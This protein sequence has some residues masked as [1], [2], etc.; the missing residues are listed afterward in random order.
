M[1]SNN[2]IHAT[3]IVLAL[4]AITAKAQVVVPSS[5][6]VPVMSTAMSQVPTVLAASKGVQNASEQASPGG[7][8]KQLEALQREKAVAELRKQV[9]EIN[10]TREASSEATKALPA[11]AVPSAKVRPIGVI[12]MPPTTA[13]PIMEAVKPDYS[14]LSIISFRGDTRADVVL[15]NIVS[16]IHVGDKLSDAKVVAI[17][18][19][20]G[21]VIERSLTK[22]GTVTN[23]PHEDALHGSVRTT[24]R[25]TL[26]RALSSPAFTSSGTTAQAH[27]RPFANSAQ[28]SLPPV[29]PTFLDVANVLVKR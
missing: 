19:N 1:P 10:G 17:S 22:A 9:R 6:A 4:C 25:I 5:L 27:D 12:G 16:T 23:G 29:M 26:T 21:V 18:L 28:L 8:L 14:V 20:D 2:N 7:T 15:G 24:E 11:A 3:A 13:F